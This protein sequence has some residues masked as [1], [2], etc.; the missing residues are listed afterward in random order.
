MFVMYLDK[1]TRRRTALYTLT[2]MVR[3]INNLALAVSSGLVRTAIYSIL[4]AKPL[5]VMVDED[6]S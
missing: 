1:K 4:R 3:L 5:V 2:V 6:D